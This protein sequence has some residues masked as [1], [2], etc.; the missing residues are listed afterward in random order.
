MPNVKRATVLAIV[1]MEKAVTLSLASAIL[2]H[3]DRPLRGP[4]CPVAR[5]AAR[6][7]IAHLAC[8]DRFIV[9]IVAHACPRFDTMTNGYGFGIDGCQ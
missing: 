3:L 6:A 9:R 1:F 7:A 4:R 2:H 5:L 8:F